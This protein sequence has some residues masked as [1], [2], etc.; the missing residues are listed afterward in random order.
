MSPFVESIARLYQAGKL[1]KEQLNKL[2]SS[3]KI[4]PQ[5]YEYICSK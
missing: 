4:T 1:S 3:G 2:L 5:E